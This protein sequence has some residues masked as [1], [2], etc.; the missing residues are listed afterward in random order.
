MNT[1]IK[2][3]K[4]TVHRKRVRP[5]TER[6]QPEEVKVAYWGMLALPFYVFR[7]ASMLL[8]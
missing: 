4:P 2:L 8:G 6:S 5:P 3:R 1:E 7:P